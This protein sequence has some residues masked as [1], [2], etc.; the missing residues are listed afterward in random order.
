MFSVPQSPA[1]TAS[2]AVPATVVAGRVIGFALVTTVAAQVVVPIGSVPVTLQTL[3]VALTGLLL[4]PR[5]AAAAMVL[6]VGAGWLGA[7]VFAAGRAGFAM[8]TAGYLLGFPMAAALI[9]RIG[10]GRHAG[11]GRQVG[12]LTL[13]MG[14]VF[15]LGVGWLAVLAGSLQ[16]AVMVGLLP[17]VWIEPAKV[18]VA[19]TLVRG[20]RQVRVGLG[21]RKGGN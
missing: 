12:A 9:S 1:G 11:P 5:E 19:V 3:A 16:E 13:G 2:A 17:F 4:R 6:Y 7:P 8:A 20:G 10:H 15:G 14:V 21:G 18:G